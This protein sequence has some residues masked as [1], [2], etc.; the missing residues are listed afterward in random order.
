MNALIN[1]IGGV[2]TVHHSLAI[3]WFNRMSR[4]DVRDSDRLHN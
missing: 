2:D 1:F 4:S 3:L